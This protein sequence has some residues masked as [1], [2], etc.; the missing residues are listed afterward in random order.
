[1]RKTLITLLAAVLC[2]VPLH[3][4]F[5]LTGDDPGHLKWYSIE[6]PHYELVYPSG[7]DSL[8]RVYGT[9]LE[10]FR[11]PMGKSIGEPRISFGMG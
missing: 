5:Y 2:A 3:A 8:A 6:T 10:Q 7:S 4:Q 1:M 9:L 11:V